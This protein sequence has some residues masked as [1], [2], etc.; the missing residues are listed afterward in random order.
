MSYNKTLFGNTVSVPESGNPS[1]GVAATAIL[2]DL[3]D[4]ADA[5]STLLISGV[6]VPKRASTTTSL[7]A[8]ATLT[9][10]HPV[11]RVSGSGA[12]V[13]LS[14]TTSIADGVVDGQI[15]KL[16]GNHATNTVTIQNGSNVQLTRGDITLAQFDSLTLAWNSTQG[17]WTEDARSSSHKFANQGSIQLFEGA[18]GG[19]N[20]ISLRAPSTLAGDITWTLPAADS[21]GFF[22]SD[23]AGNVTIGTASGV[24]LDAAY[25]GGRTITSNLGVITVNV[26]TNN[27][28][29]LLNKTGAGAGNVLEIDNDGTGNGL[30]ITQDG[31]AEAATLNRPTGGL[32]LRVRAGTSGDP[33]VSVDSNSAREARFGV[34]D[35]GNVFVGSGSNHSL[36]LRTNNTARLTVSTVGSLTHTIGSNGAII[37]TLQNMATITNPSGATVDA[38]L[39]PAGCM[40]LGVSARVTSSI[41]GCASIDVGIAGATDRFANDMGPTAGSTSDMYANGTETQPRVYAAAT[42]VRISAVGGAVNF[43][44]TGTIKITV[45]YLDLTAQTS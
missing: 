29:L 15:L 1:V 43:D 44:G 6:V 21:A 9:Q 23:G 41:G 11:H 34:V 25:I 30:L 27:Q 24:T 40:V 18:G 7:A 4:Q 5:S 42:S 12:A 37:S 33:Y 13:T 31:A 8:A 10:T 38:A 19:Q 32:V 3:I 26:S 16:V 2:D 17:D 14:G 45:I 36:E 35:A 39:I 28:G 20:K 22:Q